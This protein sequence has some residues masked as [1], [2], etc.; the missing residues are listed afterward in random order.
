[1]QSGRCSS[2]S[3][4]GEGSWEHAQGEMAADGRVLC[5]FMNGNSYMVWTVTASNVL[6]TAMKQGE[7]HGDLF[8]W[9]RFWHHQ[10][11]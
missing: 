9:W 8:R 6:A 7:F 2:T 3:W 4:N 11:A 10:L 1:M 5:Y